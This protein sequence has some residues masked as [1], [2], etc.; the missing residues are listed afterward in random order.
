MN[1]CVAKRKSE[2]KE[3]N[4]YSFAHSINAIRRLYMPSKISARILYGEKYET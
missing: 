4:F 3:R 2:E 1:V